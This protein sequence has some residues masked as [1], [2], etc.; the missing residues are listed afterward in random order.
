MLKYQWTNGT[1]PDRSSR[2]KA[3]VGNTTR[4]SNTCSEDNASIETTAQCVPITPTKTNNHH[5]NS[6]WSSHNNNHDNG[7][8]ENTCIRIGEREMMSQI[9]Q[10]PF[11]SGATSYVDQVAIQDRF[12]KPICSIET[13]KAKPNLL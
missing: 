4:I 3:G 2:K 6:G 13:D 5:M 8:R 10:N 9:G 1:I 12:L 7:Q 11:F